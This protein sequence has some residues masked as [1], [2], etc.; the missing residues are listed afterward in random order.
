V[1]CSATGH[2][3]FIRFL[4]AVEREVPADKAVHAVLDNYTPPTSTS[5]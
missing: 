1:A 5:T 3:K 2:Q 4:D